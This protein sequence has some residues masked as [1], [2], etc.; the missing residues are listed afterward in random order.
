MKIQITEEEGNKMR[1]ELSDTST[2]FANAVRRYAINSVPVLAIEE[3]TFYE[4]TSALFDE[5]LAHRLGLVPIISPAGIPKEAEINFYLDAKGPKVVYS[6][7]LET[8]DEETKIAK[9]AIPIVTLTENQA[10]RLEAK[11]KLGT[12]RRHAKFQPGLATYEIAGGVYK[13]YVES[14]FQMSPR[15]LIVRTA[16][17]L[18]EDIEDLEKQLGKAKKKK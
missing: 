7:D 13:F 17:A 6:S 3:V 8:R 5:Y 16:S 12:G 11:A 1:F 4:N 9:E 14:F 18:E 10:L 2:S 15:E